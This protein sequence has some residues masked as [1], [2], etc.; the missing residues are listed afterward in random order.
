VRMRFTKPK[1]TLRELFSRLVFNILVGNL[2]DHARN[3][4]A[5]W[6]GTA[7]T[8]TPAYDICPQPRA[9]GEASQAMLIHDQVRTSQV[10]ACLAAAGHFHLSEDEAIAIAEQEI[11]T[12]GAQWR[13]LVD[14]AALGELDRILFWGRQFL[15]AFA[16][17]G[18]E[19]KAEF[20]A[21]LA[22]KVRAEQA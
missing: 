12:I 8:L 2:D 21:D 4:A 7:L 17:Y 10:A 9:G 20:L 3:H 14:E 13:I 15:N 1:E 22:G 19:G 11:R 18:L 5:F 16:F 6:D